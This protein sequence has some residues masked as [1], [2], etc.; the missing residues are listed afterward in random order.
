MALSWEQ[1]GMAFVW[2]RRG[3]TE[4]VTPSQE[5]G[6]DIVPL[7]MSDI[8]EIIPQKTLNLTWVKCVVHHLRFVQTIKDY[9]VVFFW[10][11]MP[12][13]CLI[14]TSIIVTQIYKGDQLVSKLDPTMSE[15]SLR[16]LSQFTYHIILSLL[17]NKT[18]K[19]CNWEAVNPLL[20]PLS[21]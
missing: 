13:P 10:P 1:P 5:S 11:C 6:L 7:L 14:L 19:R 16:C 12:S 3:G 8:S 21:K 2:F 4:S 9:T 15:S 20:D 17:L 18:K